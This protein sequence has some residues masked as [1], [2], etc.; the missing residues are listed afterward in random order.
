VKVLEVLIYP[1]LRRQLFPSGYYRN[2]VPYFGV[3]K[4]PLI[5]LLR[6]DIMFV[7]PATTQQSFDV[8]KLALAKAPVLS[9]PN[10]SKT[11][12]IETDA[13]GGGIGKPY[14]LYM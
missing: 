6:K 11:F 4:K 13:S 8:R 9:I 7:W 1:P 12:V 10:F 5:D 3:I 14:C 2:F